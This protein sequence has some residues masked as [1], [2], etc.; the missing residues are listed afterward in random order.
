MP[1]LTTTSQENSCTQ[2]QK[3]LAATSFEA[4]EWLAKC[5]AQPAMCWA[6]AEM[7]SYNQ[8]TRKTAIKLSSIGC[9]EGYRHAC[10]TGATIARTLNE[11]E[12]ADNLYKQACLI[13]ERPD[14]LDGQKWASEKLTQTAWQSPETART[15]VY[16]AQWC[17]A[18]KSH[19]S[20]LIMGQRYFVNGDYAGIRLINTPT[21]EGDPP[22]LAGDILFDQGRCK[23]DA[24]SDREFIT[25]LNN[26]CSKT[27]N[28][29]RDIH[30]DVGSSDPERNRRLI[31]GKKK[32]LN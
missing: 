22:F 11:T 28:L 6:S 25:W 23:P 14:C 26:S 4:E 29:I 10:M 30:L 1:S 32:G 19:S 5:Q 21:Y 15:S 18:I 27:Y 2:W 8:N 17:E 20:D 31:L 12:T 3:K 13:I 16:S 9:Q 7:L 24:C